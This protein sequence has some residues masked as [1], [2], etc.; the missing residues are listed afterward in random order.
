M[1]AAIHFLV[2]V[3]NFFPVE[4]KNA[5]KNL[6]KSHA[7]QNLYYLLLVA[8]WAGVPEL[9]KLTIMLFDLKL[10]KSRIINRT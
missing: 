4:K 3:S 5:G 7:R 8:L 1:V 2:I 10:G 9:R 6:T